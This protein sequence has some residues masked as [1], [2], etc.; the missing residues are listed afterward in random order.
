MYKR[1]PDLSAYLKFWTLGFRISS[2]ERIFRFAP[3][4]P[5]LLRGLRSPKLVTAPFRSD[6]T[7]VCR[8]V[9]PQEN[10]GQHFQAEGK[11]P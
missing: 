3:Y 8:P 7:G 1:Q 11:A 5:L 9:S 2:Y 10:L 6:K 4:S